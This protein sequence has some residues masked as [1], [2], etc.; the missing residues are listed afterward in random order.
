M[1]TAQLLTLFRMPDDGRDDALR[2]ALELGI[3]CVDAD[4]GSLLVLDEATQELVFALTIGDQESSEALK[5]QR[6]PV[7]SGLTG[8]AALTGEVQ[9]GT[10]RYQ[11]VKQAGHREEAGLRYL[12]AAPMYSRERLVGVI[13]AAS[14]RHET[15]FSAAHAQ[16]FG[17]VAALAGIVV[18]E[19]QL[20]QQLRD[21]QAN[22]SVARTPYEALQQDVAQALQ[23]L[24][25]D[26]ASAR[27]LLV[28]LQQ[29]EALASKR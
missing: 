17:R 5:G 3:Q 15:Q 10:P 12:I 18:A 29:V 7:G 25:S 1:D 9:V 13:T 4:E 20:T 22:R 11:A 19:G 23:R 24:V 16:L 21:A 8:L 6:V 27:S 2:L 14:F 28:L 26:E